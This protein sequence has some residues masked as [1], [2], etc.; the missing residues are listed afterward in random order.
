MHARQYAVIV[1]QSFSS[2]SVL[3][4]A[5]EYFSPP[6]YPTHE[7]EKEMKTITEERKRERGQRWNKVGAVEQVT[8]SFVT[9]A[10]C[11]VIA[12]RDFCL[13]VRAKQEKIFLP[14]PSFFLELIF[15]S[16]FLS[17]SLSCSGVIQKC[18]TTMRPL[19]FDLPP[20]SRE[21]GK[22]EQ[23]NNISTDIVNGCV[24]TIWNLVLPCFCTFAYDFLQPRSSPGR[25]RFSDRPFH[26]KLTAY[27]AI[28]YC[29]CLIVVNKCS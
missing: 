10:N 29:S 22:K 26:V 11:A 21:V 17:L 6:D 14:S 20:M 28:Q 23:L 12:I 1:K 8:K 5:L 2:S 27:L 9:P 7:W 4:Q 16:W 13:R 15:P 24:T 19:R 25:P 18:K 3:F